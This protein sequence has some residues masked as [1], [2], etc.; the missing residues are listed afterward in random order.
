MN[1]GAAIPSDL[2]RVF[3]DSFAGN[4]CSS[5]GHVSGLQTMSRSS[6]KRKDCYMYKRIRLF[7]K[8]PSTCLKL[9][10]SSTKHNLF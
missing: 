8:L 4:T 9:N 2:L 10:H 5:A 3:C 1:R 7:W 6:R